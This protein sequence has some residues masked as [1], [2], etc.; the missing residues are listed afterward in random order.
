MAD[1]ADGRMTDPEANIPPEVR[2]LLDNLDLEADESFLTRRQ[3]LVLAMRE[4]GLAQAVIADHLG[5]SRANVSNIERSARDNIEKARATLAYAQVLAA[6]VR[7]QLPADLPMHE[8]PER[9]YAACDEAGVKVQYGAPELIRMIA[10]SVDGA[11]D[12]GSL[13]EDVVVTV[14]G[15][16]EIHVFTPA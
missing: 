8:A 4:R 15:D 13:P 14:T 16:G 2:S 11:D 5:C 7:V 6:P 1:D 12:R 10:A 3:A 9:V